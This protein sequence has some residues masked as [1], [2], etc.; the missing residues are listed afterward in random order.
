MR[1]ILCKIR[2]NPKWGVLMN[3]HNKINQA[4]YTKET[5]ERIIFQVRRDSGIKDK[6]KDYSILHNKSMNEIVTEALL[7]WFDK[8]EN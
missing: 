8:H 6:L 2:V 3:T 1:L 5:Y 7:E 4:K